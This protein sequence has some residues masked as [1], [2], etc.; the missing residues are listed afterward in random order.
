MERLKTI[1][2]MS[3]SS[4]QVLKLIS[5]DHYMKSFHVHWTLGEILEKAGY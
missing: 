2:F 1:M 5:V 4:S 3:Y